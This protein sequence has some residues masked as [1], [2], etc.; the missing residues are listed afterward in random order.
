MPALPPTPSPQFPRTQLLTLLETIS[1]VKCRWT[2]RAYGHL[3]QPMVG[4]RAWLEVSVLAI[5]RK[6]I[7]ELRQVYLPSIDQNDNILVGQRVATITLDARSV[8]PSLEAIDLLERVAFRL[9]TQTARDLMVPTIAL[10]DI[11]PITM[12]PGIVAQNR[13]TMR[14]TMDVRFAY[15]LG[16]DPTGPG[17]GGYIAQVDSASGGVI[18]GTLLP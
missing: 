15:V 18:P 9:R 7:D 13:E 8:D 1:A 3:G 16:D 17:E 14:A 10:V 12:L 4:E 5:A 11:Q 6:G 2:T